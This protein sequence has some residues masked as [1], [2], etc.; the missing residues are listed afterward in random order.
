MLYSILWNEASKLDTLCN[1]SCV[2]RGQKTLYRSI[3]VVV[4]RKTVLCFY[5]LPHMSKVAYTDP[6]QDYLKSKL[7]AQA[8]WIPRILK[9]SS[10]QIRWKCD[11]RVNSWP[12]QPTPLPIY[13]NIACHSNMFRRSPE[14]YTS[15]PIHRILYAALS[16]CQGGPLR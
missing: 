3:A 14:V 2:A 10:R 12:T 5:C 7:K 9:G 4:E 15:T 6:I 1:L 13:L 16:I 11:G 8:L